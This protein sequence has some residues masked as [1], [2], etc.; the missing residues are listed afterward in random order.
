MRTWERDRRLQEDRALTARVNVEFRLFGP[1]RDAAGTNQ[2]AVETDANTYRELLGELEGRHPEL[3]GEL[4][5]AEGTDLAGDTVVTKNGT[6][7][8]HLDGLETPVEDG[9]VVRAVPSV[10]GGSDTTSVHILLYDGFDELDAIGPYEVFDYAREFGVGIDPSYR[11]LEPVEQV[12]A[13]HGTRIL[14]DGT[15]PE[16]GA[17]DAPD[18]LVVPGGGWSS[19][20]GEAS[21]WVEAQRGDVPRAL[22]AHHRAGARVAG[23]CT[24]GLLLATA[25]LTDD[26][27]AVTHASALEEL[28]E[29][30]ADVRDAR[31]VDDGDLLT[32]GGVTSGLDLA[33]YL[34]ERI[35]DP[36]VADTDVADPDV[37]DRIATVIEYDRRFDVVRTAGTDATGGRDESE[38]D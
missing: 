29:T 33:L 22:S 13:S 2:L 34:V 15:L 20:D 24:G 7:V 6:D 12:T 31:V 37:A 5:D 25:G 10:Y 4:L 8:R 11:T 21:A 19:R 36:D 17:S 14:P 1:F 28:R 35:A 23:V 18:L 16:P 27:P 3:E 32:A 26:R 30:G 9:D 38:F